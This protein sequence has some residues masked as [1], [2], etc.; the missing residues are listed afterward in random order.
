MFD[1]LPGTFPAKCTVGGVDVLRRDI[2]GEELAFPDGYELFFCVQFYS[3][4]I[5]V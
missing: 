2:D 4:M 5:I 1:V 3:P